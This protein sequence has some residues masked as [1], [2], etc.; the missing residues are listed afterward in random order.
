[1]SL[2]LTPTYDTGATAKA[3]PAVSVAPQSLVDD[4]M[5][6]EQLPDW[7]MNTPF[8]ADVL[9][10]ALTHERCGRHLYRSV[11]GRTLNPMLKARYADFGDETERHV[12]ILT[13]LIT[14]M[15]G[16]PQYVSPMAR[17]TEASDTKLLESTFLLTGSVDVMTA[18]MVMLEAVML[19]ETIDRSN[20]EAIAALAE[21]IPEGPI[22]DQM[23]GA[24]S[25]V[26]DEENEHL[27][28]AF[29][30]RLQMISL[31]TK[32]RTLTSAAGTAE[33][34]LDRVR[35]LFD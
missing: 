15:G 1:M 3:A 35:S 10:S 33:Q 6:A 2:I 7:G 29:K 8:I 30:T 13:E 34:I 9:S 32:S 11:E 23:T 12:E 21:S 22:R 24:V 17:A 31:Q 16:S 20:W 28:W 14:A 18:E 5:L 25:E 19:A 4:D 27:E 26:L